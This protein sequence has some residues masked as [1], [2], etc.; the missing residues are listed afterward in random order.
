MLDAHAP[1][2]GQRVRLMQARERNQEF[3]RCEQR[4]VDLRWG[5][6]FA[7]AVDDAMSDGEERF[8]TEHL[9]RARYESFER[10]FVARSAFERFREPLDEPTLAQ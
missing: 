1:D 7:P 8:V 3:Q 2:Q 6:V 5:D 10:R 4:V 9:S